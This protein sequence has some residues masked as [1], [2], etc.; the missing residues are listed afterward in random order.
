MIKSRDNLP[1]IEK[2]RP[3]K[4]DDISHQDEVIK[5]VKKSLLKSNLQHL[6][7]YG[8]PGTGKTSTILAITRELFGSKVKERVLELNASDDRG[9][10]TVKEKIK[11][12]AKMS[13][14]DSDC[15]N[16][17]IIILDEADCM[18]EYAQSALKKIM[19]TYSKKTR[20]CLI[21]NYV[22]KIIEPIASRCVKLR[23][24]LLD[25]K[26][27]SIKIKD[28]CKKENIKYDE[29]IISTL[30]ELSS[31]DM[32]K[33]ISLLQIASKVFLNHKITSDDILIIAGAIPSTIITQIMDVLKNSGNIKK[34]VNFLINEAYPI[35]EV[36]NRLLPIIINSPKIKN[37]NDICIILAQT[38][39]RLICGT[40]EYIQ[41]YNMLCQI[42][43][44][45]V[46]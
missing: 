19:E 28:I 45:M 12:F 7:F 34:L 24:Q 18:T 6:L 33:I 44:K 13:L 4:L 25:E 29:S 8:P 37:K 22:T 27:I 15:P 46:I 14:S 32:R 35:N 26:S 17:K 38:E 11:L 9:I 16:Y 31:G 10:D 36:I 21:C 42:Q 3:Q 30:I 5:I 40:D 1:W 39:Y 41:L 43:S 23:F 2:Y 20:F